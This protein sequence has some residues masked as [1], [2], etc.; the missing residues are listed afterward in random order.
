MLGETAPLLPRQQKHTSRWQS[1]YWLCTSVLFVALSSSFIN[2]P[3]TQLVENNICSQYYQQSALTDRKCK[4]DK[5]QSKVAY[6]IGNLNLGEA[7]VGLLVA[8]PFGTLADRI[9]RKPVLILSITGSTLTTAWEL[10]VI[11]LPKIIN[12]Q[13]ALAGPLLT[14]IGGGNTV[15]L[16]NMYSIASDL[17]DQSD[18]ASTFFLMAFAALVGGAIGP[19]ISSKLMDSYIPLEGKLLGAKMECMMMVR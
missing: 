16:A 12:I 18:R 5:I 8:F 15:L 6:L 7:V 1:V 19:A 14:V 11:A 4:T 3:I 17:A 13:A 2:V 10:G 9:G